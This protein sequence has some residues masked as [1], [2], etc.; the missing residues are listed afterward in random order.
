MLSKNTIVVT[1]FYAK[2]RKYKFDNFDSFT[3]CISFFFEKYYVSSV[4]I[5]TYGKN[6]LH[7]FILTEIFKMVGGMHMI[8]TKHKIF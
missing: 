1:L 4:G 5:A 3:I 6:L 7:T 8:E 2:S